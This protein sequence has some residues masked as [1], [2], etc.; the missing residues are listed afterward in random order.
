MAAISDLRRLGGR[1]A[2]GVIVLAATSCEDTKPLPAPGAHG[3]I[4]FQVY[5]EPGRPPTVLL[6]GRI[7]QRGLSEKDLGFACEPVLL[8]LTLASGMID[9]RAPRAVLAP[10]SDEV[11]MSG[12]IRISGVFKGLP[13]VGRAESAALRGK[14]RTLRLTAVELIHAGTLSTSPE[15]EMT[16]GSRTIAPRGLTQVDASAHQRAWLASLPSPVPMGD[17]LTADQVR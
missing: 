16:E 10:G 1:V 2:A 5:D 8:R 14:D 7:D 15:L 6:T 9:I 17:A 3:R 13:L 4:V 11:T 12:P